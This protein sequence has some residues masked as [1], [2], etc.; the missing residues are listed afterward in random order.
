VLYLRTIYHSRIITRN[1]TSGSGLVENIWGRLQVDQFNKDPADDRF[2]SKYASRLGVGPNMNLVYWASD[3]S[4]V[5]I[6][7]HVAALLD[8]CRTFKTLDEHA[9]K[10]ADAFARSGRGVRSPDI[11]SIRNH[12]AALAEAGILISESAVLEACRRQSD[13]I[14]PRIATVGVITRDRSESLAQ[15]LTSFIENSKRFNREND[16]V[17]MDDSTDPRTRTG[18]KELLKQLKREHDVKV[19]YAGREEKML[20]ANSLVSEGQFDPELVNFA[21]TDS[22]GYEFSCGKNRNALFLHTIGDSI[23]ST[24]DDALCRVVAPPE[25]DPAKEQI[26]RGQPLTPMEFWFYPNRE[27]ALCAASYRE[28]DL[29]ALHEEFLGRRLGDCLASFGDFDLLSPEQPMS[30]HLRRLR[31]GRVL[32]TLSGMLGDSGMRV[33]AAYK[34]LSR[35]SRQRL[36]ESKAA[37]LS[38]GSSREVMRVATRYCLSNRTWFISTALACDNRDLLPP[39]FPVLRGTDGI[40]SATFSRCCEH[41]YL[42]DIPRAVLHAPR[43]QRSYNR[44]AVIQSAGGVTMHSLVI[45]CILSRHFWPGQSDGAERMRS[46]GKH[47]VEIGSMSLSDFEEFA[48]VHLWQQLTSMI[49]NLEKDLADY[50]EAPDYWVNDLQ[51]YLEAVR[52]SLIKPEF[53]IPFDLR[54]NR[55]PEQAR[56]LSQTLITRFGRL[57][58]EWPDMIEAARS[59]RSRGERLASPI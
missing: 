57:L 39:F 53:V 13:E 33:P 20:F 29:L 38:A 10:S 1:P 34:V 36:I 45:A 18:N 54:K 14:P 47:L 11:D 31:S 55:R 3:R 26:P 15:C 7:H 42:G 28:E 19:S 46:V 41:G 48:R 50:Q 16:F 49:T 35:A 2:C 44:E 56:K 58:A 32:V 17:V 5:I 8:Q 21:L 30:Q 9:A 24:D 37:Y 27:E 22:D 52:A 51:L 6:P 23:F 40:F 4:A 25:S 59:L 43:Q 12:L